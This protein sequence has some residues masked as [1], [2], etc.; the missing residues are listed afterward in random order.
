VKSPTRR[1]RLVTFCTIVS[2][3][4]VCFFIVTAN[5]R[6]QD[7]K[8]A[9][10]AK[11]QAAAAAQ[12]AKNTQTLSQLVQTFA[13]KYPDQVNVVVT[14]LSDGATATYKP[15]QEVV[16]ASLYKLFVAYGIYKRVDEGSLSLKTPLETGQTVDGCLNLM[17][18]IS[19]NDCGEALGALL[20][21]AKLDNLLQSQGYTSTKLDNYDADGTLNGDKLTSASDVALLLGRLYRGTLLQ[22][23]TSSDFLTYLK[24]DKINTFLPSGL[25]AGTTVA[26][27]IGELYGYIHDAGIVYGSKTNI[28]VVLMTGEWNNPMTDAPPVFAQLSSA[29][30]QYQLH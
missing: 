29:V 3:S 10:Q 18:T 21:W 23:T 24:Q 17:I 28:L 16:S 13:T 1:L 6:A 12:L 26:H 9:E 14:D 7:A 15:D 25:P 19:D 27:K 20:G 8:M 5:A 4:C 30:W 2:L 22:S 11:E